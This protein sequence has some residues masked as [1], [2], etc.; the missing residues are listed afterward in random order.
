MAD[1]PPSDPAPVAN[2]PAAASPQGALPIVHSTPAKPSRWFAIRDVPSQFE[3]LILA[4]C[5]VGLVMLV[6]HILTMG[7]AEKRLVNSY[8]LPSIG[9]TFGSFHSLW[10]DRALSLSALWSLGRVVGGFAMA[11]AIGVPLGVIAGSYLRVNAF[12]KPMSIFGRNVPV[13]A[14][15]PLTLIWFGLGE[16]QKVMF[17]FLATVAFILFDTTNAIQSVPDRYLDTGYTLGARRL[18][19]GAA[20]RTAWIALVYGLLLAFGGYLLRDDPDT[21][22]G[23]T[24]EIT[25]SGFWIRMAGGFVIGFALWLPI[26][27]HQAIRSILLPLAMPD[28]VNSLRL[29]FGIAFGYIMLA[30]VINAKRGLG[31]IIIVSQRRGPREHI[32]LCLVIISLLAFAIDRLILSIQRRAFPYVKNVQA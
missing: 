17:I 3:A 12:L 8:T 26:Q 6:W 11:A 31:D 1:D 4:L 22:R 7:S 24:D 23:I 28:I 18:G 25:A 5:C 9:E 20:K 10:F 19:W 29:L 27:N 21:A 13:A 32:Y 15:I 2:A 16:V 14:L 30:E